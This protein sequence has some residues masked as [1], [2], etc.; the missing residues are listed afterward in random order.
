MTEPA[1]KPVNKLDHPFDRIPDSEE[2]FEVGPGVYWVRMPLD[3]T[4]LDHINL[5]LLE[6]GEGWTLVDTGMNSDTIRGH[7]ET[8]F[9]DKLSD[10][11]ITRVICTHFHPDHMGLAGWVVE[12]F[13]CQLW[14]SRGEYTF[15]RM[16]ASSP[17]D[18]SPEYVID[19]FRSI[20]LKEEALEM[21][22]KRGHHSYRNMVWPIPG[23]F[24]RIKH[25]D[26][27][28]IGNHRWRVVRGTGHSPE[29]SCLHSDELKLLISG[30]QVLPRITPHI[31]V[32]PDE[33][34]GNPLQDYIDSLTE[35]MALPDDVLV[36][37]AHGDPFHGLHKRL[38]YL[39]EH[40]QERLD[41]LE[42][43]VTE[44][45]KLLSTLKVLFQ[46]R[47]GDFEAFLGMAESLS[48]LNCLI[49][50]GRVV[51]SVGEDGVWL[52][53]RCDRTAAA[54]D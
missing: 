18:S 13:D 10:K 1:K 23:Q 28:V 40:H 24:H 42:L 33:P 36:L 43:Y 21:L 38:T 26:D 17:S 51:R 11:P 22:R 20:G 31:G 46:R 25:N 48:H 41:A 45:T 34:E 39:M 54:A 35:L 6:D 19:H 8:I 9:A 47:L 14:M 49:E 27:L 16:V 3:L 2:L 30:D 52:Y 5:W 15:G 29:H 53:T 4:G 50:Q 37:P 12:K 44:P 32:Y 7:W